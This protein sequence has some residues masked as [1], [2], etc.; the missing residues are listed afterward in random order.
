M[1]QSG[2]TRSQQDGGEGVG[3]GAKG[4]LRLSGWDVSANAGRGAG[5]SG[6]ELLGRLERV[7]WGM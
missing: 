3:E 1:G 7:C 6:A 5:G 4:S 2:V